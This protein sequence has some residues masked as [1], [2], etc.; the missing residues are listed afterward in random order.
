MAAFTESTW[1]SMAWSAVTS[2][3]ARLP[4]AMRSASPLAIIARTAGLASDWT[5]LGQL[6]S[7][8]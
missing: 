4:E 7:A 6:R 3:P 5:G 1:A 2:A 8:A